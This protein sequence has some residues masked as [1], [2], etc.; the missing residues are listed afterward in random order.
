[1]AKPRSLPTCHAS[2]GSCIPGCWSKEWEWNHFAVKKYRKAFDSP[3]ECCLCSDVTELAQEADST[4][5]LCTRCSLGH[6]SLSNQ[7]ASRGFFSVH[8][9]PFQ[10]SGDNHWVRGCSLGDILGI[11]HLSIGYW[12]TLASTLLLLHCA[13]QKS[14][15]LGARLCFQFQLI[16]TSFVVLGKLLNCSMLVSICKSG[17]DSTYFIGLILNLNIYK[18]SILI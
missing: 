4:A 12:V 18:Y 16:I 7:A 3:K 2:S 15:D 11:P 6:L 17:D 5:Q 8:S 13:V 10:L 14:I 1:M 9:N